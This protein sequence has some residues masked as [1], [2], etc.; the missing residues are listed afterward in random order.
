[1]TRIL[2]QVLIRKPGNA[3][4]RMPRMA[5]RTDKLNRPRALNPNE[6]EDREAAEGVI[7]GPRIFGEVTL[8]N[9]PRKYFRRLMA[10]V[11]TLTFQSENIPEPLTP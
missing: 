11:L 8:A 5:R 9:K 1:M 3:E 7:E 10:L 6:A 2:L 4:R